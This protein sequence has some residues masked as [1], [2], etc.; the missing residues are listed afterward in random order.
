LDYLYVR[1]LASPYTVNT[2]PEQTLLNFAD[3]GTL[4][5][6]LSPGAGDAEE[7][8]FKMSRIGIDVDALA[9]QLQKEGAE[10][11]VKSWDELMTVLNAKAKA[12][13]SNA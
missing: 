5:S 10:S 1:A 12:Q 2:M 4:G 7:L 8:L 3:H 6:V 11:F 9:A 13:L